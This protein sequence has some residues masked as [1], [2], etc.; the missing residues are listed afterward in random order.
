MKKVLYRIRQYIL[1]RFLH[2][3]EHKTAHIEEGAGSVNR[4]P[5]L[6]ENEGAKSVLLGLSG[7]ID[8]AVVAA[9]AVDALGCE[10]VRGVALPSKFSSTGSVQ[11]AQ[12]LAENLGIKFDIIA[13]FV[14]IL[15]KKR[16][17]AYT[18]I[19]IF[20]HFKGYFA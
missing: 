13:R 8:S 6:L 7:G 10:N 9:L 1:S 14:T 20:M 12:A 16:K 15:L 17:M 2:L 19:F 18:K 4:I 5:S 3:T 11:D